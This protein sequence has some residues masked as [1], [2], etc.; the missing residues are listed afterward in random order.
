MEDMYLDRAVTLDPSSPFEMPQCPRCGDDFVRRLRQCGAVETILGRL[1]IFPFRCQLCALR[2]WSRSSGLQP[3]SWERRKYARI[4][5]WLEAELSGKDITGTGVVLDL[6]VKGCGIQ[7]DM[8]LHLKDNLSLA[9]HL[10]ASHP[11]ITVETA[12]V[13]SVAGNR[14]GLEFF[15]MEASEKTR[16]YL[17]MKCL[18]LGAKPQTIV[19]WLG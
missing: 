3:R 11:P 9:I 5:V 17:H 13:R 6:S 8:A 15:Q 16:L 7:G 19:G 1:Y 14:F 4:P 12:I 10:Y 2:F 18:L